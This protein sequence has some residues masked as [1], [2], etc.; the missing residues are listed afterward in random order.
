ML[1]GKAADGDVFGYMGRF[2]LQLSVLREGGAREFLVW[3]RPGTRKFSALPA[4]VSAWLRR[5]AFDLTTDAHGA[6]RA[7]I[8]IGAYERVMPMD[9][10][11]TYLL[12]ALAV[13]DVER[14]EQLGCLEL[15]EEDLALCSFVDPGKADFGP[16]LRRNLEL[17]EKAG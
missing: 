3:L 12:R 2:D 16:M 14:A 5:R 17:I 6:P 13:D 8:P 4:F 11:P 15:D 9:V 1:S 7:I 10:L